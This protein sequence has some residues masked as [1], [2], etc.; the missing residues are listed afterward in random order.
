VIAASVLTIVLLMGLGWQVWQS[1]LDHVG[2]QKQAFPI[3]ALRDRIIHY[4]EILTMSANMAA[5]TGDPQWEQRYRQFEPRLDEAIKTLRRLVPGPLD[6]AAAIQTDEANVK[7]V[8]MEN[9]VFELIARKRLEQAQAILSSD[10]YS[11][12]KKLYSDG[13][14]R[15]A[16]NLEDHITVDL[17]SHRGSALIAVV[18]VLLGLP[19][20][21]LLW[22]WVL[23]NMRRNL[24]ERDLAE[25]ALKE[26][27]K[28]YRMLFEQ[29]ADATLII[30]GDKFIDCNEATVEMLGYTNKRQLLQTHPSQL[31]PEFQ[32]DGKSS[33]EKAN[34]M[35]SIA[36]ERGSHRF[37]WA[38][39][40]CN[41]EVFPVEVLLTVV[42][43]ADR[44]F[45]HVV[46]RDITARK[47]SEEERELLLKTLTAKNEELQ[48]I[49]YV[50]SHDLTSPLVNIQGFSGEL[51]NAC[52]QI[53][54]VLHSA[55][56]PVNIKRELATVLDEDIPESLS[57]IHAGTLKM[58]AL[59][60]G[61]LEVSRVGTTA[62]KQEA[63]DMNGMMALI[64]AGMQFQITNSG[65]DV[66]IDDLPD[67]IG[68]A[69][70]INQVFSN[71]LNNAIKYLNPDRK[72]VIHAS[73]QVQGGES[74]F[75]IEDN[76]L[77]I[78]PAHQPKIFELFHRLEPRGD[79][80][81]EGL[82]LTIARRILSRE[83]GRIWLESEPG[84]GSRFFVSLPRA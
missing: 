29:S 2:A 16:A 61:L 66:T 71:L 79:V 62:F 32:P 15:V 23:Q 26:R 46:W 38:H 55:G 65:A 51:A 53:E 34:E 83:G 80:K 84:K 14:E 82:G 39:K 78:A 60:K 58:Q 50:A 21:A 69:N 64:V 67:C 9:Q 18:S 43:L 72:G 28:Q 17:E 42:A 1:Y 13:M 54:S 4:D 47:R 49:V 75:C 20:L 63:I 81:G 56:T 31:S 70:H 57:F 8:E 3:Q 44:K 7:L 25:R 27:E 59:L 40:R 37:E 68:D 11:R 30:E 73:G 41:G 12:Q 76:G 36:F 48:S 6:S 52:E 10:D 22:L 45:L 19:F 74:I 77:G 35:M 33:F 24:R 5:A